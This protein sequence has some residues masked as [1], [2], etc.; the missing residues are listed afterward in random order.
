[1][2]SQLVCKGCARRLNIAKVGKPPGCGKRSVHG[3]H[4][5][6]HLACPSVACS[7]L[8]QLS[9]CSCV[10]STLLSSSLLILLILLSLAPTVTSMSL[11]TL[12]HRLQEGS[13]RS[14][15]TKWPISQ[16]DDHPHS[17]MEGVTNNAL[18]VQNHTPDQGPFNSSACWLRGTSLSYADDAV[19][20]PSSPNPLAPGPSPLHQPA[21]KRG[22]LLV[23]SNSLHTTNGLNNSTSL[24]GT[25]ITSASDGPTLK[26]S[27]AGPENASGSPANAQVR[28]SLSGKA[29]GSSIDA[30]DTAMAGLFAILLELRNQIK[31]HRAEL[32]KRGATI[33][34]RV[35][36]DDKVVRVL[37][38]VVKKT[39]A[40]EQVRQAEER[41]TKQGCW[42]AQW[43]ALQTK[44]KH[45]TKSVSLSSR[46][47]SSNR[48]TTRKLK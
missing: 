28:P 41:A 5:V 31:Y 3:L 39:T 32:T 13:S 42:S 35:N 47:L 26:G 37:E 18:L 43:A 27:C 36:W 1:M 34:N 33:N 29:G 20:K 21:N 12:C 24:A 19:H 9:L 48:S 23:K 2:R 46:A 10:A 11:Q 30:A 22:C 15:K 7:K 8:A 17:T 38:D 6:R 25:A 14:G 45:V 40:A 4:G 16:P 44:H